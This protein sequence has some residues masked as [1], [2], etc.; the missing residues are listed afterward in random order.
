[1][2]GG[3]KQRIAIARALLKNPRI[4]LLDE[5]TSSLDTHSERIVHDALDQASVGRTTIIIAHHL[6]TLCKANLIAVIQS[7]EV[8]ELGSHDELAQTDKG[9]YSTMLHLQQSTKETDASDSDAQTEQTANNNNKMTSSS[10]T[11]IMKSSAGSSFTQD[12]GFNDKKEMSKSP[13]PSQ[14]RL[15]QMN[16]PEFKEALF[17]SLGAIGFGAVQPL[18]SYCMGSIASVYFIKDNELIKSQTR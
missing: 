7:G 11:I 13:S 3:Q 15:L 12:H 18:S 1:M 17:G 8:V 9:A 6:S 10:P 16:S 14:W 2:S 5:A 4:L